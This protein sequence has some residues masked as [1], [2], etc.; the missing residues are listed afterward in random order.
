ML[1]LALWLVAGIAILYLVVRVGI[2][3]L[4]RPPRV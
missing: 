4:M 1:D 2:A 3:W